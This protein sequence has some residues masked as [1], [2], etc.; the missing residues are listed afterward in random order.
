MRGEN[1]KFIAA[2]HLRRFQYPERDALPL[3]SY[4]DALGVHPHAKR[5]LD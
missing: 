5:N 4:I 3:F 1:G 2:Q